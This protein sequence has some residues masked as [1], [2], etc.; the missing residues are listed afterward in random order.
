MVNL[1]RSSNMEKGQDLDDYP[2]SILEARMT[3][4]Q[5]KFCLSYKDGTFENIINKNPFLLKLN[6]GAVT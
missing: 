4:G 2:F 5:L 6:E 1:L 3:E